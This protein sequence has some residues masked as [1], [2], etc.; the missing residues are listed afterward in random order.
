MAMCLEIDPTLQGKQQAPP[1]PDDPNAETQKGWDL[2]PDLGT[3]GEIFRDL[4]RIVRELCGASRAAEG[5]VDADGAKE[6]DAIH[7]IVGI[8][9]Q[10][11]L[12]ESALRIGLVV[13]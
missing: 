2:F 1:C 10:R 6:C 13:R 3:E 9:C 12:A 5:V 8:F 11:V 7:F 4:L